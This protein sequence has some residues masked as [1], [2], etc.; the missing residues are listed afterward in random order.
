MEQYLLDN[1]EDEIVILLNDTNNKSYG[2][3]Q[4]R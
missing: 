4:V 1:Y 3:L 2:T